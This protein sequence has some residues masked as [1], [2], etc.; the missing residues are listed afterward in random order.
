[1]PAPFCRSARL[2]YNHPDSPGVYLNA[3]IGEPSETLRDHTEPDDLPAPSASQA[4]Q[5]TGGVQCDEDGAEREVTSIVPLLGEAVPVADPEQRAQEPPQEQNG[6]WSAE[7]G[8]ET[9]AQD[10]QGASEVGMGEGAHPSL[11]GPVRP[12]RDR[13]RPAWTTDFQ[14]GSD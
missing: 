8:L 7:P 3:K 6:D 4:S 10:Q 14:L 13:R 1:M 2:A 5:A 9:S 12:Q 11:M